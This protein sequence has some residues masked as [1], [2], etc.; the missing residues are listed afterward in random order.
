MTVKPHDANRAFWDAS[1]EWWKEK[2]DARGLWRRTAAEPSLAFTPAEMPFVRDVAGRAVCVL[3]SG[4]QEAAFAFAGLG[5]VVTSVDISAR[6]LE[7]AAERAR[8]LGLTLT[9]VRADVTDLSPLDRESFDLVYTGG[10]VSIWVSDIAKYYAEA[11]RILKRGGSFVVNEYHPIRRMWSGSEGAKPAHRYFDRGP[12]EYESTFEYHWTVSDHIQA[13][14][15]AGCRIDRIEEHGDGM[16][17]EYWTAADLAALP[18]YLL[19]VGT[20]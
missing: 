5:A 9:F 19:M 15:D 18:A 16:G 10:H 13:V 6:R 1:A 4:D 20:K 7:I 12:Y 14:I 17:D 3:G 11:V 2:E 8:T